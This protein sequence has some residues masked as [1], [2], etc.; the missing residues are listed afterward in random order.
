M[1]KLT[2]KYLQALTIADAGKTIRDEGGLSAKVAL[3]QKGISLSFYYQFRWE[4][5][6]SR[7]AC[8]TW[9]GADLKAIREIR[10]NAR[11]CI[12]LGLNPNEQKCSDRHQRKTEAAEQLAL[13]E[14]LKKQE[15]TV[16]DLAQEWLLNGVARKD[17]NA[18]LVASPKIFTRYWA[19]SLCVKLPNMIY[20]MPCATFL[21]ARPTDKRSAF[22]RTL[23]KCSSGP[24][25]VSLGAL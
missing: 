4:G 15:L 16:Y 2:V 9:P 21:R 13:A 5:K 22:L 6:Y 17:N 12:A 14:T 11:Q 1:T 3:T 19:K 23:P 24:A 7:H 25:N 10:D 8:G 20:A 18:E